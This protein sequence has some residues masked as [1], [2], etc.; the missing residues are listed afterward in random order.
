MAPLLR[1]VRDFIAS[2]QT[3]T[4]CEF[5]V[6]GYDPEEA[7]QIADELMLL[8]VRQVADGVLQGEEACEVAD[9]LV[10]LDDMGLEKWYA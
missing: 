1:K 10:K 4:Q 6:T 8:F 5:H 9:A 7:H 2:I 3:R